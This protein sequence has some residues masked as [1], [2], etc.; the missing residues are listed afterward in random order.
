MQGSVVRRRSMLLRGAA[1][2]LCAPALMMSHAGF[3]QAQQANSQA[4]QAEGAEALEEIIVTGSRIPNA[5]LSLSVPVNVVDAQQLEFSGE[6]NVAGI[7]Q[8]IPSLV[9]T[10]TS[11]AG[12]VS[13]LNLRNLGEERTLTLI[14]GK[15][16]IAS[17]VG[18]SA[19]DTDTIPF[20][21]I[22]RVE[23]LTG[24]ASAL[25]GADGVTGV[26]NFILRDDFEG[27]E[28]RTV[29]NISDKGDNE[30]ILA[31][32][33]AGRNFHDGRG[34][35]FVSFEAFLQDNLR[36]GE[37]GADEPSFEILVDN[38][39]EEAEPGD[40]PTI[41]DRVFA[42]DVRF[43][44][45]A[46]EGLV[47][48]GAG[49]FLGTGEPFDPGIIV[50][51]G[52]NSIGGNG[53]LVALLGETLAAERERYTTTFNANYE[54]AD[55]LTSTIRFKYSRTENKTFG[56]PSFDDFIPVQLDNAF[57][58][59]SIPN[60]GA[61]GLPLVFISKD[62]FDLGIRGDEDKSNLFRG[63]LEFEGNIT[64]NL[65]YEFSYVVG[66]VE[67][68]S[69]QLNN[70]I[71]DRFF[72]ATDAVVDP[73]TGNI[74]CR[75]DLDPNATLPTFF[76]TA[77]GAPTFSAIS[78]FDARK[79]GDTFTPGPN[80]GCV[81]INLFGPEGV[82]EE[83]RAF[84][85]NNTKTDQSLRQHVVT[86][87]VSGDS[88]GL[89][90]LPAGA[91]G[92]AL[93]GEFRREKSVSVP[94]E[95]L[96]EGLTFGNQV[97]PT[98]GDFEVYEFFGEV[99]VP[100]LKDKP[101]ADALEVR[102]AGRFSDYD[103]IGT[104]WTWTVNGLWRPVEDLTFRGS[105]ASAVR[106]PNISELFQ[107]QNQAFFLPNDPCDQDFL[108]EGSEFRVQNCADALSALGI[109]PTAFQSNLTAT[110]PGTTQGNPE[111]EEEEGDTYTA[112]LVFTPS[113]VPGFSLTV[114]YWNTEITGGILTPSSQ[115]IV[116]E[117][118]DAPTLQNQFCELLGRDPETGNLN[119]LT[120]QTVNIASFD[121]AGV[122]V[123]AEYEFELADLFGS[124]R[125]L[126]VLN[127]RSTGSWLE[128]LDLT[129][130][131]GGSVDDEVGEDGTLLGD[132]APEFIINTDVTWT[133]DRWAINYQLRW[134]DS[135]LRTGVES[136]DL[137]NDPDLQQPFRLKDFREH[138]IFV[139]YQVTD[140]LRLAAGSVDFTTSDRETGFI[141]QAATFF[142][143]VNFSMN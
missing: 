119:A 31:S 41:P 32:L 25:Y 82:S 87:S 91:I 94:D 4:Q 70:R 74:V 66:A 58:P 40:D 127:L 22:E 65:D 130:T 103:T 17:L 39:D 138:S 23:V 83:A 112:G 12:G 106:A 81:P 54:F 78:S 116:N 121:A 102:A 120:V 108:D 1:F 29:G 123:E 99:N 56:D 2:G 36:Q 50:G 57:F 28:A 88:E 125:N 109:D 140:Y 9:G 85:N 115:D 117:C 61:F 73:A 132:E 16:H 118:F 35:V 92:Y 45:T 63:V 27:I 90:D 10:T 24:G 26:V 72:A 129:T 75:T 64:D 142:F 37:R 113:F 30:N 95:L 86:A 100:L 105:I 68:T 128:K 84:I 136:D 51:G 96:Q 97:F 15:R 59:D 48:T 20:S 77:S 5:N 13:A 107:P 67:Q 101:F 80:S 143:R 47:M 44:F 60:A 93:G 114:D 14:D 104:T 79:F 133:Y 33:T 134:Q 71:E 21:L 131:P 53:E 42:Q 43:P 6:T 98:I 11:A 19:V 38:P 139:S 137:A 69:I 126:G 18:T 141:E 52:R 62:H 110:F 124:S 55:W 76:T 7:L 135:L 34:N 49:D 3:A 89:V 8:E 46:P 111:L 122:D